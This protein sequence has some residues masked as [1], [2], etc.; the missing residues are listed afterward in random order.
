LRALK[1][2]ETMSERR[3]GSFRYLAGGTMIIVGV[4][5]MLQ[6]L[7]VIDELTWAFWPVVLILLGIIILARG[8]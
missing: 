7:A 6:K 4:L 8:R 2:E 1:E 3:G 5:I